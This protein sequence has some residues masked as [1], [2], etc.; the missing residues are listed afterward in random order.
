M[1]PPDQAQ[2]VALQQKTSNLELENKLLKREV[3]S[4]NDELSVV[5]GRVK[6]TSESVTRYKNEIASLREQVSRSDHMIRELRSHEEDLQATLEA[7]DAQI[8]VSICLLDVCV[9][10]VN[11]FTSVYRC[12]G[13]S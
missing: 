9:V 13:H 11:V 2:L 8:Q 7:R 12:C 4:L 6:E 1:A 5:M 10:H 3:A